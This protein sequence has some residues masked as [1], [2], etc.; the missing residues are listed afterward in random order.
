MKIIYLNL[1]QCPRDNTYLEKSL[2]HTVEVDYCP[3][4]LGMWFDADEFRLS[5]DDKDERLNWMDI[6]LWRDKGR[7]AVAASNRMCPVCRIGL[8]QVQYDDSKVRV[9][10]CKKCQGVWLDRGEFKQVINYLKNKSDYELL[11]HYARDL[12]KELWEAFTGPES[13]KEEV[14]DVLMLIKLFNYKFITQYP[15]LTHLIENAQK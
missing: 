15:M 13:F 14:G 6:D 11:N 2:F 4:C 12:Q 9:D 3:E 10:F 1:M 8:T 5:K 7:F